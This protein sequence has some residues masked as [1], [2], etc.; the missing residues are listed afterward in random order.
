MKKIIS[1]TAAI[2]LFTLLLCSCSAAMTEEELKEIAGPL[3]EKSYEINE[4]YFGS[5]LPV[6]EEELALIGGESGVGEDEGEYDI[7]PVSFVPVKSDKYDSIQSLKDAALEVYTESYLETV[8]KFAFEGMTDE[9]GE[10]LQYARYI[11]NF[12]G[13]VLQ[14]RADL[15]EESIV[16]GRVFDISTIR[17]KSAARNYVY[18]TV[19]SYLDGKPEGTV[20]LSIKDEGSGWRLDSPTY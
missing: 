20:E 13:S 6:D 7:K 14:E 19:E 4:I 15:E 2:I 8:F 17:L 18:F 11:E 16:V 9:K 12:G 1:F 3:I 10:I 5:G